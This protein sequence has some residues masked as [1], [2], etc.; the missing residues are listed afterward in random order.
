MPNTRRERIIIAV[1]ERAGTITQANGYNTDIGRNTLR[2]TTKVDPTLLPACV[3]FPLVETSEKIGSGDYLCTMPVKIEAVALVGTD[4][5]SVVS[6][7][8]LGDI[9][10]A[11]TGSPITPLIEETLYASGG[12][13]DY[14]RK[15]TVAVTTLF[16]IKYFSK[17]TDP[18]E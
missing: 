9:R 5:P 10:K 6:E 1:V 16:T 17:I 4:N 14:S 12:T 18:Y 3:I 13:N 8:I 2:A 7:L 11:L 15:D